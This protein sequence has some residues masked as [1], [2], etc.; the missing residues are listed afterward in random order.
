MHMTHTKYNTP[1]P[2]QIPNTPTTISFPTNSQKY[3]NTNTNTKTNTNTNT[4]TITNT[5]LSFAFSNMSIIFYIFLI[6]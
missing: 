5:K 3:T 6:S 2:N 4:N 1:P